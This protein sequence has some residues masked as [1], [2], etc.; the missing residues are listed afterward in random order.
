MEQGISSVLLQN[1]QRDEETRT[2]INITQ[3]KHIYVPGQCY[4]RLWNA[5]YSYY[6]ISFMLYRNGINTNYLEIILLY[7]WIW[8]IISSDL[9]TIFGTDT[10]I[11]Y[12]TK[13]SKLIP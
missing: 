8:N 1:D 7:T 12:L 4:Y 6:K 10:G 13:I 5:F 2:R 3:L 11:H 9:K